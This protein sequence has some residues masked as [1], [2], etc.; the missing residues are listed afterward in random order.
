MEINKRSGSYVTIDVN[1]DMGVHLQL[2]ILSTEV[3]QDWGP[4]RKPPHPPWM[5]GASITSALENNKSRFL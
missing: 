2:P 1:Q 4:Q 5:D 3:A